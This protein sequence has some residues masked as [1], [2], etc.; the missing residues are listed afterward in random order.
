MKKK[1]LFNSNGFC[2]LGGRNVAMWTEQV[3]K[4]SNTGSS[5]A[6]YYFFILNSYNFTKK[7]DDFKILT[8]IKK[9]KT[10]QR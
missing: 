10:N 2:N 1:K 9:E 4:L 6:W 3:P 5:L 7:I 8:T